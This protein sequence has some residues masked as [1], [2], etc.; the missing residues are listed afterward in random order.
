MID[1]I[2]IG[3][4]M[5]ASLALCTV[6]AYFDP[7][8]AA[9]GFGFTMMA[10]YLLQDR[11]RRNGWE[12]GV[13]S[14]LE[15]LRED[16]TELAR[17]V[18]RLKDRKEE[19][20]ATPEKPA[21]GFERFLFPARR[22]RSL[23]ETDIR[24]SAVN[25]NGPGGGD[26]ISLHE[27]GPHTQASAPASSPATASKE[28]EFR[29]SAKAI[30]PVRYEELYGNDVQEEPLA[31]TPDKA[32]PAT[33]PPTIANDELLAYFESLSDTVIRELIHHAVRNRSVNVF[34]QPIVRLPQ[35][36]PRFFEMFA[37]I[38]AR[39]GLYV[40]ASRY[41]EVARK[42]A[43]LN[44]IDQLLLMQCLKTV[45]DT[46][47]LNRA[48]PFF[49]NVEASN[50]KNKRF[51]DE[52]LVF[53]SQNRALAPRLIFE[54]R[55]KDLGGMS[56]QVLEILKGLGKLGC[57]LSI[58]HVR[59]FSFDIAFLRSLNTQFIKIEAGILMKKAKM[60]GGP[61]QIITVKDTLEDHGI[62]IIVEKIESEEVLR[63]LLDYGI[64]YGQGFLFGRPDL[65]AMQTG[66]A[67]QAGN[68]LIG[69]AS[70]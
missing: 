3:A 55:Q 31:L 39:P 68:T 58:D 69:R 48:A 27:D 11:T 59:Q 51:M 70:S 7:L 18:K 25:E 12:T 63:E 62:D 54:I 56:P 45:R 22:A 32:L 65:Q 38:R 28:E 67:R 30:G 29:T 64:N 49:L 8:T 1:R 24:A 35:R 44:D 26:K 13:S 33:P 14:A 2:V 57:T 15:E 10:F 52:L 37:R 60:P 20:T 40:P 4:G 34:V 43:V 46:A 66:E 53:L 50:L 9:L 19:K 6:M 36:K 42:D 61:S 41:I 47:H 23:P 16:Q 17:E 5:I 21:K